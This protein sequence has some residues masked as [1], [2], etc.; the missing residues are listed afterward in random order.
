[1]KKKPPKNYG[2]KDLSLL[3][4]T[5]T[6]HNTLNKTVAMDGKGWCKST[7]WNPSVGSTEPQVRDNLYIMYTIDNDIRN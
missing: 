3:N 6:K 1:M 7:W 4:Y 5:T 2:K